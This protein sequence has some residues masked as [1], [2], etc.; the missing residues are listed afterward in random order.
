ML[1]QSRFWPDYVG[2]RVA[3]RLR[4]ACFALFLAAPGL[5][6]ALGVASIGGE[7]SEACRLS[8]RP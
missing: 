7:A 3:R 8:K 2:Q 4:T 5:S 1:F 6:A